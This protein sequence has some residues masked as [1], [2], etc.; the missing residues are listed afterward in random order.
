LMQVSGLDLSFLFK[1]SE[2]M[3]PS[4]FHARV[5]FGS[6]VIGF[7]P[8]IASTVLGA[9]IAGIGIY[10]RQTSQLFKELEV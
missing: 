4:V 5:T 3:M 7:A 10:K 8:G 2:L 9:A 6:F 1:N